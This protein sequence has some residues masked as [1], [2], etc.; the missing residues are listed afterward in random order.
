MCTSH[1]KTPLHFLLHSTRFT[2]NMTFRMDYALEMSS[3]PASHYIL[4]GSRIHALN[5][6]DD[7]SRYLHRAYFHFPTQTLPVPTEC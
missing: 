2:F 6:I 5:A 4:V 7:T 1:M 3:N